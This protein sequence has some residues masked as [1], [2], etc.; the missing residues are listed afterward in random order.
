M[1]LAMSGFE[2]DGAPAPEAFILL[3]NI[4]D[5]FFVV[6]D[7]EMRKILCCAATDCA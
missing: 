7:D 6:V 1:T 4:R 5:N 2:D 3:G